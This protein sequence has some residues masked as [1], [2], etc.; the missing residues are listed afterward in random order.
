MKKKKSNRNDRQQIKIKRKLKRNAQNAIK[1]D[2]MMRDGV[3]IYGDGL[4]SQTIEFDDINYITENDEQRQKIFNNFMGLLNSSANNLD[5]QMTIINKPIDEEEYKKKIYLEKKDDDLNSLRDEWNDIINQKLKSDTS[6]IE[7]KRYLTYT[8]KEDNLERARKSLDVLT[9]EIRNKL[10]RDIHAKSHVCTGA[11]RLQTI[12]NILHPYKDFIFSYENI[13]ESMTTKDAIA[14]DSFD[15]RQFDFFKT[16]ERYCKVLY[17][18]KWSTEVHDELIYR[19]SKLEFNQV[20]S[21][22]MKSISRGE[23]ISLIKTQIAQMELEK[24][25]FQ[26]KAINN[27]YDPEMLPLEFQYSY[28]EAKALLEDVQQRNQRLFDTQFLIMLNASSQEELNSQEADIQAIFKELGCELGTL[29]FEQEEGMNACL[30]I[31]NM[32]SGKTRLL[33]TAACSIFIPFISKEIFDNNGLYYGVNSTTGNLLIIDRTKL[34]VANGWIF[35]KPGSGKSYAA[36]KE[37]WLVALKTD[38]DIIVIDP[39]NEYSRFIRRLG[40]EVAEISINSTDKI[41][42]W[43]GD[44]NT[45]DFLTSKMQF[46]QSYSATIMGGITG[47][48]ANEK[49]VVDRVSRRLYENYADRRIKEGDKAKPPTGLEYY[50]ILKLQQE[51]EAKNMA[52]AHELYSIGSYSLFAGESNINT[53][54]RMMCY[55][56][57]D[58]DEVLRPLGMT[59]ILESLWNRIVNNFKNGKRTWI[60]VDEIYLLFKYDYSANFFYELYKRIRKYGGIV[61]GITQNV[62]EILESTKARS[63]LSNSEFIMMFNQAQSDAEELAEL[64]NISDAQ[65]EHLQKAVPGKGIVSVSRDIIT[66]ED[67]TDKNTEFYKMATT[68]FEEVH[69]QVE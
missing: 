20:I 43:E 29:N 28:D 34:S 46:A 9:R 67:E 62:E 42:P 10:E 64:L 52:V 23:D 17:L 11:E 56:I 26:K 59:V 6:R 57:R 2:M 55:S 21:F 69:S 61:T 40:G 1:Y 39:E 15:F 58:L 8:V 36:K 27:D 4:F 49:S 24:I 19:L 3:C 14:P 25:A 32:Y 66:F 41:N 45:S 35:G 60:W 44:I 33:T 54:N 53:S 63:M 12:Y 38:D 48:T 18:K 50:K 30:P 68:K 47:L 31:G 7:T 22:H 51:E 16:N 37:I 13:D 65:I 5:L